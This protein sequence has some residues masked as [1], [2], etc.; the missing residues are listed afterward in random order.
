MTKSTTRTKADVAGVVGRKNLII[1]GG[2]D[3]WQRGTSASYSA[4]TGRGY[5]V[6]RWYAEGYPLNIT[7]TKSTLTYDGIS[8]KSASL[9]SITGGWSFFQAIEGARIVNHNK[10]MTFSFVASGSG[11]V[12]PESWAGAT[13]NFGSSITLT[14]TPTRYE[15]THTL[16]AAA[17]GDDL[18]I[19]L[20]GSGGSMNITLAQLELGS[21]ATDFEHR[22]FG[23]ELAL[24]QR[25]YQNTGTGY[26]YTTVLGLG[27]A[28]T[29]TSVIVHHELR[30]PMRTT[31]SLSSNG[32][33]QT[34]QTGVT[35]ITN[36]V[37]ST[38]SPT[39]V[40][41]DYTTSGVNVGEPYGARNVNDANAYIAFDAEL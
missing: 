10:T 26:A 37:M 27:Y 41:V 13:R 23:E 34:T 11:T 18:Y 6:D 39:N 2:F 14:S 24:C 33:F 12:Q 32:T 35:G 4:N 8:H 36:I 21:V 19:G 20:V 38:S 31:P 30:V 29:T 1:N 28:N 17:T 40:R 9:S 25:Y 15:I 16:E 7:I 22:S 5:I 3:V